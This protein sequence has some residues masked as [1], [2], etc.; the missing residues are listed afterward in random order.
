LSGSV[1]VISYDSATDFL[2]AGFRPS[3]LN[4]TANFE[5][6]RPGGF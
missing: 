6:F 2:D 3:R 5:L 1:V 4:V